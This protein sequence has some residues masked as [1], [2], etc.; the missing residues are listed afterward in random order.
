MTVEQDREAELELMVRA[1]FARYGVSVGSVELGRQ[2]K[3]P[4]HRL[5]CRI[6]TA[7]AH[8]VTFTPSSSVVSPGFEAV[9]WTMGLDQTFSTAPARTMRGCIALVVRGLRGWARAER[10]RMVAICDE[11]E[12]ALGMKRRGRRGAAEACQ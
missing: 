9:V 5:T 11:T 12:V 6:R 7:W 10:K 8:D 4:D 1:E 2:G 3:V